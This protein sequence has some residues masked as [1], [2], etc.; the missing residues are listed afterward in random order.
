MPQFTQFPRLP[1]GDAVVAVDQLIRALTAIPEEGEP[2]KALRTRLKKADLWNRDRLPVLLRFFRLA[3]GSGDDAQ[4]MGRTE[5]VTT[6]Q[7]VARS[8]RTSFFWSVPGD[9]PRGR[10]R[11]T[12]LLLQ[13]ME[14]AMPVGGEVRISEAQRGAWDVT[15]EAE[16][17]IIDEPLWDSLSNPRSRVKVSAAQVQFALLA[18]D[19]AQSAARMSLKITPTKISARF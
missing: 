1:R 3:Y 11:T 2:F 14:S 19:L 13:C 9:Q 4:P 10:V 8:G 6:L 12:F 7:A 18:E 16:R 17:F 5:I 15:A